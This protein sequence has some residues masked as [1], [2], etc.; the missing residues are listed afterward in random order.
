MSLAACQVHPTLNSPHTPIHIRFSLILPYSCTMADSDDS[1]PLLPE[2]ISEWRKHVEQARFKSTSLHT[3][4]KLH[5][6]STIQEEQYFQFHVIRVE[7]KPSQFDWDKAGLAEWKDQAKHLLENYRSWHRYCEYLKSDKIPES[8]FA[9]VRFHQR[10]AARVRSEEM[11]TSAS[12][13]PPKYNMRER[14]NPTTYADMVEQTGRLT[15]S[16]DPFLTP[17]RQTGKAQPVHEESEDDSPL[18]GKGKATKRQFIDTPSSLKSSGDPEL[19]KFIFPATIDEQIVNTALL[20]LLS[21]L[22]IHFDLPLEW[23]LHRV[24]LVADFATASF[25]ARTDGYL[26]ATQKTKEGKAIRALVEVKAVLRDKKKKDICMQEAAQTVAW[27]KKLPDIGGHLNMKGRRIHVCQ[28]RHEIY[29][30]YA[31]YD[32]EYL[33]YLGGEE[34][35]DAF[36][37]LYEFGPWDTEDLEH[38][39]HLAP[40]LVSI[41]L[42]ANADLKAYNA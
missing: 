23:T 16:Y 40:I 28:D 19:R 9:L 4:E 11:S 29:I 21:A 31:E 1:R 27:I 2:S 39:V 6:A 41:A 18:V 32:N 24:P 12:A 17:V 14:K 35:P 30:I 22:I 37:T 15:I 10:Q 34:K 13:S 36:M 42:R 8:T 7:K 25:E 3:A 33:E 20:S 5:S 38:M 26:E